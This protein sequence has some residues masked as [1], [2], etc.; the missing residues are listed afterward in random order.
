M[1]LENLNLVGL[2]AQE[3]QD[4]DG[5]WRITLTGILDDIPGN[6]HLTAFGWQIF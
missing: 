4:V 2:D 1:N 3:L 6:T 5:G